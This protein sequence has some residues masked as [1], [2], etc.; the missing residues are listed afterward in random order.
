MDALLQSLQ[1]FFAPAFTLWGSPVSALEIVA[2]VLAVVMVVL[3]MRVNP[4]GWPL[5]IISSLLYFALFW[6]SKLYGDASL[7]ILFAVVA[8]WGWWQWLRGTADDG[9]ALQV[10]ELPARGRWWLLAALAFAWPATG[11]FLKT[12]TDTDVPWWDAFPTAA[13]VIGQWLLG[14]KYIENWA[15]WV[16]VN[17]VSVGLFAYKGL[18]LTMLLYGLFIAMSFMGWRAWARLI[19]R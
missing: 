15:A 9:A 16:V 4:L 11:L 7:Q 19:V 2:F 5:A 6:S 12:Y 14:R 13:S 18:W 3:N 8:L 10:R 1:P 17:I